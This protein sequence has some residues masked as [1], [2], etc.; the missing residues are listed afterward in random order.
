MR[1]MVL[2]ELKTPLQWAEMADR[3]PGPNEIRV[4]VSACGVH[5]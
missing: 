1:A 2:N 3:L 5:P 4:K